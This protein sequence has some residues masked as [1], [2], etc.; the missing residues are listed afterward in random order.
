MS[1]T[2]PSFVTTAVINGST[3]VS[4]A[5]EQ[6]NIM[7][8]EI[9][10]YVESTYDSVAAQVVNETQVIKDD[11]F[12]LYE[13]F[14]SRYLGAY[15][16]DPLVDALGNPLSAGAM[17]FSTTDN[18]LKV[19]NG[20]T[21]QPALADVLVKGQNLADVDSVPT[22]RTNLDVYS[23]AE[24][25]DVSNTAQRHGIVEGALEVSVD[26]VDVDLLVIT[27]GDYYI[28]G[29]KYT[30]PGGTLNTASLTAGDFG[31]VGIN[32]GGSLVLKSNSFFTELE[33]QDVLEITAFAKFT[34]TTVDVIADSK[35]H[36][37]TFIRDMMIRAK[38]FEGTYFNGTAGLIT[39]NTTPL[40]LDIAGGYIN[41]P[42][43]ETKL[44]TASSNISGA[45]I[46]RTA[47]VYD[48]VQ[49]SPL[50]I[51]ILQYDAGSLTA[52]PNNKFVTHTVARSSRTGTVYVIYGDTIYNSEGDAK[53][54][55]YNL[56]TF[57][58]TESTSEV[59]PIANIVVKQGTG[60]VP[61]GIVDLR[62]GSSNV[63]SKVFANLT[64]QTA[65][66][67]SGIPEIQLHAGKPLE[68]RNDVG[69][70]NTVLQK[71]TNA[72]GSTIASVNKTGFVG[73][74][75]GNASTASTLQT[76]RNITLSGDV[77]GSAS[78][79]GSSNVT[80]TAVV[81][82]D[83]H[84]HIIANVDGL[85]TALNSKANQATTYTKTE[86]DN[87]IAALVDTAPATLDTL[88]ELAAALGDDPNFATTVA[89]NIGNVNTDLQ[90]H[91]T[92]T[93]NPHGVTKAQVGLGLADNTADASKNV[94]S[95]T[96][97]TTPRTVTLSGDVAGSASVD[98]S[99]N[100]TITTTV[101]P[102]SVA[103]GTD[104]T[105]N[106]MVNV[107]AG[108][109]I[110]VSHTQGEGSTATITNTAPNVTTNI[111]T[112]HN[113]TNVIVN[114]S[115]GT[116]G[117]INGATQ[118]LA[119]VM[120]AA[121]KTKLDGIATGATANTGTVTSVA[122]SGAITGGTITTSG[123]ISHSTADGYLHVPATGTTNSGKVLTA[124]ATAGS[125]SWTTLPSAPVTSVAGKTGAVTLD[126]GD[127]GLGSVDNTADSTKKV[128]SATKLTTARTISLAGDVTGS[129]SFDGSANATITATVV[130][131]SHNHIIANVDGLQTAL[132]GKL[133][134]TGKAADSNLLD[135]YD[136]SYFS[137]STHTHDILYTIDNRD[138]KPNTSGIG[139]MTRAIRGFFSTLGGMTGTANTDYQDVLVLDTY[140][141]TTGGNANAITIDKSDG[142]MRLWNASQTATTWGTPKIVWTSGNDGAGSGLDADLLDGQHGSY[143]Q[144]ASNLN[145]GT[146]P[147][148][149]ISGSYT[150][151][152]NLTGSGTVDF[153][154]FLGNA[155]DT[156]K[157]PSF[158]W[159]GDDNTGIYS[160]G[161]DQIAITTGGVQRA[162]FNSSGISGVGSRLTSLTGNNIVWGTS[163]TSGKF[164]TGTATPTGTTRL[165]YSGYFHPT[166]LNLG[167]SNDTTTGATHYFVE[168][169]SD[170]YVR[171]KTLANVR[172]E[173]VTK[174]A[175]EASGAVLGGGATGGGTDQVF[176]END[177]VVTTSYSITAGKNA[178]STGDV[179][180][181]TGV[182]VTVPTGSRWVII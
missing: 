73:A 71:W 12:A 124:G 178:M 89:T 16:S 19:Y 134:T 169:G 131:D 42:N 103:L 127:V 9:K 49:Q 165:N 117:T 128:L 34:N 172:T 97:W 62:R 100:V 29:V 36:V 151:M 95:A 133:S 88:N 60:I 113:A 160:P 118:T 87:A 145:A 108:T 46:Y 168:T 52:I 112:T 101:Q 164:Y 13:D 140:S 33:L 86:V 119:G 17:Y 143:Y 141:D 54:A 59:E 56:G 69:D 130:D 77:T 176:Y 171:P 99:A 78:F 80:I 6:F 18:E 142:V 2:I 121:D 39:E 44:I 10:A 43:A 14:L 181:N 61:N 28:N 155:A 93:S 162:L 35:F 79:N 41:T 174:A 146:V 135:G 116:N 7:M 129:V 159:T 96:K 15:V 166:Y 57:A 92:N 51:D 175:V 26:S 138:M 4:Q 68:I 84:N 76:A 144:N 139:S 179:T 20:S 163:N 154:K 125:L 152:T 48:I 74:L 157:A 120:T 32:A 21:F 147:D 25:Y 109:G 83:S 1:I 38:A 137:V 5:D 64:L 45:L 170:G 149:R 173:I 40:H 150:G 50:V 37:T 132:D 27:T 126:K 111:T 102:N 23:K 65:Y 30:Y 148:A 81:Q 67:L 72:N 98:G 91:K 70:S 8:N 123:T 3:L 31:T 22:A 167:A 104:T 161:A 153:A 94:L 24:S 11:T 85:Q 180:I 106:Y 47:G 105:G 82:D 122:T 58:N 177:Q 63:V 55:P 75:S 136:S 66:D 158:S 115:D 53:Q 110:S 107:T 156:V 90:G 114:S 182:T